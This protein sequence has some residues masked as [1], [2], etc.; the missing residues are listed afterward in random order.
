MERN[1][2][3][4]D[5]VPLRAVACVNGLSGHDAGICKT[6]KQPSVTLVKGACTGCMTPASVVEDDGCCAID[7]DHCHR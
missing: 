3:D 7:D 1:I 5:V 4:V 2:L 6:C